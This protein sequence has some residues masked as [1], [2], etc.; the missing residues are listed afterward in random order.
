MAETLRLIHLQ[1][2][3][4][5]THNPL[6]SK[7]IKFENLHKVVKNKNNNQPK[8]KRFWNTDE[9]SHVKLLLTFSE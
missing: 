5:T 8:S 9:L 3:A 4:E 1:Q 2:P 7:M 6:S